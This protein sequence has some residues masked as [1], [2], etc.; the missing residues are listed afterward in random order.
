MK[1]WRLLPALLIA[2][3]I[4]V[5]LIWWEQGRTANILL[6]DAVAHVAAEDAAG[7]SSA[8]GGTLMVSV[9]IENSGGADWLISADSPVATM[10]KLRP[11]PG[12]NG[13]PIPGQAAPSLAPDGAHLLL[14]GVSGAL[15]DGRLAPFTLTFAHA[16]GVDGKATLRVVDAGG[17]A[18]GDPMAHVRPD[19]PPPEGPTPDVSFV[20][21]PDG[22]GWRVTVDA[23]DFRFAP[24]AMDGE[25]APGEGHGHLYVDGLKIMRMTAPEVTIG[26]LPPGRHEISVVL[27]ANDHRPYL[28]DGAPVGDAVA[29]DVE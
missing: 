22:T 28:K 23:G 6:R 2:L 16:G 25:H 13:L 26:A 17:A 19:A 18:P 12:P 20:V 15:K 24:A 27:N 5:A 4:V 10:A 7:A 8:S 14:F 9:T 3:L 29:I 21:E 11:A 1:T